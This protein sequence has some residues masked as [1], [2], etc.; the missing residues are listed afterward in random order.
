MARGAQVDGTERDVG[1]APGTRVRPPARVPEV[2][3]GLA[4]LQ[5]S[6]G[7]AAVSALLAG[8]EPG[9]PAVQRTRIDLDGA[10]VPGSS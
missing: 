9:P 6:A 5:R 10:A 7:N 8:R 2:L 3:G 1:G 4:A